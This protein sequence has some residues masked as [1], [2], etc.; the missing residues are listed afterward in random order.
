M[1]MTL[2]YGS[3][4]ARIRPAHPATTQ[5]SVRLCLLPNSV[6]SLTPNRPGMTLRCETGTLWLTQAGDHMDYFLKVGES[7]Q[8][9]GS[10]LLVVQALGESSLSV[11]S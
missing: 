2:T 4:R 6:L 11:S 3:V 8:P 1:E 9:K 5:A 7:F 10:G